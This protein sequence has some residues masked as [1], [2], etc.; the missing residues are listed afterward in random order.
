M[1]MG[2]PH[3]GGELGAE[4]PRAGRGG[5]GSRGAVGHAGGKPAHPGVEEVSSSRAG[6]P[7]AVC[8]DEVLHLSSV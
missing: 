3:K 8:P 7:E 6:R 2:M 4:H 1:G 5:G